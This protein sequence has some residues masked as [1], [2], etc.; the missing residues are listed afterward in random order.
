MLFNSVAYLLFFPTVT[1]L[2]FLLPQRVRWA[3][4]LLASCVFYAAFVPAYLLILA[5]TI[6]VDYVAG[7]L[8]ESTTSARRRLYLVASIV[9][10]VGVLCVF[11]YWN[12]LNGNL[13]AVL[14]LA[15][16]RNHVPMLTMALP[17]GLSFHTFQAMSYTIEVYRGRQRAE[18]HLGIYALYVM[19]FPQLVAGPIERPQRLLFQFRE[20][21]TF[22]PVR[23]AQG[24]K[25]MA[26]GFFK[27]LVIADNLAIVAA[28]VFATPSAYSGSAQALAAVCFAF[29]I[30]CDFS[31]YSEIA[32]GSARVL[33]FTLMQ[34]FD[35]PY[36]STSVTEFWRRWHISLSSWFKD[37]LYFPLGG[38][39]RG[40]LRSV[41][42]KMVVFVV[43]GLWHGAN[44]TFVVW[45]A[46]H[47]TYTVIEQLARARWIA[48]A[49]AERRPG[50]LGRLLGGAITFS[51]VCLAW[52]FFKADSVS[53]AWGMVK[54]ILTL[55]PASAPQPGGGAL[56]H[57]IVYLALVPLLMAAEAYDARHGL[58]ARIERFGAPFRYAVYLVLVY[59]TILFHGASTQFIYFQF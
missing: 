35:R 25:I 30:Y 5:F 3:H 27:K 46:L 6:A 48:W 14:A 40:P 21:Q 41:V 2:F 17:I 54:S 12:F 34:N 18:R 24:L 7:I 31:G 45:G 49:G 20:R 47:G 51:L 29:R 44:W 37:Y 38:N 56:D 19:F 53:V 55:A 22:D 15:G 16:A 33:G 57:R 26:W 10:N 43:S 58:F 50:L 39:R 52:V 36:Q 13:T 28:P 42:N 9:A 23:V 4:L 11:K 8:I 1:L 32:L 59:S